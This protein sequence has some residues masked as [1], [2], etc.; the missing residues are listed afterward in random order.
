MGLEAP[1]LSTFGILATNLSQ[2]VNQ[3]AYAIFGA[4]FFATCVYK[5]TFCFNL[6]ALPGQIHGLAW[7]YA[8]QHIT[9]IPTNTKTSMSHMYYKPV[10]Q[11]WK[12]AELR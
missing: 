2:G 5:D 12:S 11:A 10:S 7:W 3:I 4:K 1:K 9:I 6:V 8:S